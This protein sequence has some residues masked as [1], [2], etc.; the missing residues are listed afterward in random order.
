MAGMSMIHEVAL[1]GMLTHRRLH[2]RQVHPAAGGEFFPKG[3]GLFEGFD[4]FRFG[5]IVA[6]GSLDD[7]LIAETW[8]PQFCRHT[9]RQGLAAAGGAT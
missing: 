5:N 8:P 7:H 3:R 2:K 6:F 9:L 4:E 1:F